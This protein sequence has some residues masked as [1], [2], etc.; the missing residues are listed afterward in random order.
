MPL[1]AWV[2]GLGLWG[3][4]AFVLGYAVAVVAFVP[5]SVLTLAAGAIFGVCEGTVCVLVGATLGI[6]G[7]LPAL[8]HRGARRGELARSRAIAASPRST[9]PSGS[10]AAGSCSCSA[11][12]R[13][14][15]STC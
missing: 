3:P 12:R 4:L 6:D 11:S 8:A 13:S 9:A 5:G 10:R 14:S 1:R 15:R 7:G 2:D